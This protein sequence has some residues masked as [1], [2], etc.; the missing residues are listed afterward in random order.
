M[1]SNDEHSVQWGQETSNT[2][3]LISS[4]IQHHEVNK[5][6][7]NESSKEYYNKV[8][9]DLLSGSATAGHICRLN[10][11]LCGEVAL[12]IS[13][14]ILQN[15]SGSIESVISTL[16]MAW[17]S[18]EH[19]TK[20]NLDESVP[21]T[22]IHTALTSSLCKFD[23]SALPTF[24]SEEAI[25][26]CIAVIRVFLPYVQ[27]NIFCKSQP[28]L[29]STDPLAWRNRQN[30]GET[31]VAV[32]N[33]ISSL[34]TLFTAELQKNPPSES[35]AWA[36]VCLSQIT[37]ELDLKRLPLLHS[38]KHLCVS[39]IPFMQLPLLNQIPNF[40]LAPILTSNFAQNYEA[41]CEQP[42]NVLF[43]PTG[44][45]TSNEF[46]LIMQKKKKLT[47]RNASNPQPG[48]SASSSSQHN[49]HNFQAISN[50]RASTGTNVIHIG[51][52]PP[53]IKTETETRTEIQ[54]HH[55]PPPSRSYSPTPANPTSSGNNN[56]PII[57]TSKIVHIPP[58]AP[59]ATFSFKLQSL[60]ARGTE[61]R[62]AYFIVHG[63]YEVYVS[64]ERPG[65]EF[66]GVFLRLATSPQANVRA[67]FTNFNI[68]I[69]ADSPNETLLRAAKAKGARLEL[70]SGKGWVK[71]ATYGQMAQMMSN[72]HPL[73][74]SVDILKIDPIE[75]AALS[76]HFP[77]AANA[78][79]PVVEHFMIGGGDETPT[80][81]AS[82][83]STLKFASTEKNYTP[84]NRPKN[85]IH[86]KHNEDEECN[87]SDSSSYQYNHH[88][89]RPHT[90]TTAEVFFGQNGVSYSHLPFSFDNNNSNVI[91]KNIRNNDASSTIN[92]NMNREGKDKS[93]HSSAHSQSYSFVSSNLDKDVVP[94]QSSLH[95]QHAASSSSLL[96]VEA[97]AIRSQICALEQALRHVS[98]VATSLSSGY[99]LNGDGSSHNF[100][101]EDTE[102]NCTGSLNVSACSSYAADGEFAKKDG[103]LAVEAF[104]NS[105]R[106]IQAGMPSS[107]LMS[108]RPERPRK[109]TSATTPIIG[110]SSSLM[111]VR[112]SVL[113]GGKGKNPI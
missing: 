73:N 16:V 105:E 61:I 89:E 81:T 96:E 38:V 54:V 57:A 109:P 95:H 112:G 106:E 21:E 90:S 13:E 4:H 24:I 23:F 85:E 102:S 8:I 78:Q 72:G 104:G 65:D 69:T 97:A 31:T 15:F 80:P 34:L 9:M 77:L 45:V 71:F 64:F 108:S 48:F 56:P 113:K 86:Y 28:F 75:E 12:E 30:S 18:W 11:V 33:H 60:P 66:V 79:S 82:N 29:F 19:L 10:E 110:S 55:S 47:L 50:G 88:H 101:G 93:P 25:L 37:I 14:L 84:T 1:T 44:E 39:H 92:L 87:Q 32:C 111:M 43:S 5:F 107:S 67:I 22:L 27:Q 2:V 58:D 51:S 74:I 6:N 40:F 94:P 20:L 42:S 68:A 7:T 53:I 17:F 70:G 99:Q 83:M 49:S 59:L 62:S 41:N 3:D 100:K 91:Q 36:V 26:D 76:K 63:G 103:A 52:S 46:A 35:T 98:S